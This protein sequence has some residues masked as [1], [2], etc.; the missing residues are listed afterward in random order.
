LPPGTSA[1]SHEKLT[2]A[3]VTLLFVATTEPSELLGA[4]KAYHLTAGPP[5]KLLVQWFLCWD[6]T[7]TIFAIHRALQITQCVNLRVVLCVTLQ[8][9]QCADLRRLLYVTKPQTKSAWS[10]ARLNFRIRSFS[11]AIGAPRCIAG[12]MHALYRGRVKPSLLTQ[13][14]PLAISRRIR[15]KVAPAYKG[16]RR[17]AKS[18]SHASGAAGS[19]RKPTLRPIPINLQA[20]LRDHSSTGSAAD[21]STSFIRS[22]FTRALLNAGI[23]PNPRRTKQS[24]SPSSRPARLDCLEPVS[25]NEAVLNKQY[26]E[27]TLNTV[28]FCRCQSRHRAKSQTRQTRQ[29]R[30]S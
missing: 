30:S 8:I 6:V 12:Q 21:G 18:S 25:N 9:M 29:T 26:S 2:P 15:A 10:T 3:V 20:S 28:P 17:P 13:V 16:L 27:T 23:S 1:S 5:A 7:V 24:G 11:M 14:L 4:I 22:R 19:M